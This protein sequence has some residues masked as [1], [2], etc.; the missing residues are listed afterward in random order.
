MGLTDLTLIVMTAAVTM[1]GVGNSLQTNDKA[2]GV[3]D[4]I[5]L[6]FISDNHCRVGSTANCVRDGTANIGDE[7]GAG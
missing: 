5:E 7:G 1:Q 2:T 3:A 4:L 6:D